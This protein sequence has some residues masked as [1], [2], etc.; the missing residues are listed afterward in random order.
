MTKNIISSIQWITE[1]KEKISCDEKI[2][3][4]ETNLIEFNDL[5]T[6]IYDEAI[7]IGVSKKQIKDVL[8]N[9][10]KKIESNL[11]K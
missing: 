4:L 1:N 2:K 9:I 11:K 3:V 5:L 7:L 6:D 10:V 8:L